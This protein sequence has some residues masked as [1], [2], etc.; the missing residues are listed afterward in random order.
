MTAALF[1]FMTFF[2][3]TSTAGDITITPQY[4]IVVPAE[5]TKNEMHAATVLQ[6]YLK[7]ISGKSLRIVKEN[8]YK[9]EPAI[10]VGNTSAAEALGKIKS[11][12][13]VIASN[14]Q[15]VFIKGG[16][17]KGVVYGVYTLLETYLGCRKYSNG[18]ASV[19]SGKVSL[20]SKLN[21]R[22]E[23]AFIYRETY[24]PSAFDNEFLEWHKL[25]RFEDLWGVWGHSFFKI[26]PPKTYF[27]AHPEYYALV[28][29]KRQATQLC[30]SNDAVFNIA[31][32]Y[33]RKAIADNP[34][35]MY[36]S[37]GAEDG[38]GFCTCDQCSK[39]STE[40]GGPQGPLVRFVNR[41]A[42]K[43]PRQTF[44][45]LAYL[46]TARPPQK[47]KPAANVYIMLSSIDAE[48]QVPL[49][50]ANSFVKNLDGWGAV[51]D[52]LFLWDYTTQFTNYLTPF[53]DYNQQ[54]PNLQF[55]AGKKVKGIFLQGSGNTYGD[56]A[57]L[58]AYLQAKLLWNPAAKNVMNEFIDGYYG[59]SAPAI[60]EYIDALTATVQQSASKLDIYGGPVNVPYLTPASI[61]KYSALLDKAEKAAEKTTLPRI[62]NARLPLE[63]AVLQQSRF[64]GTEQYGYLIP[65]GNG[66]T[67]NP[68]W[69]ARVQ[70]FTAQ[71]KAAG[72]TELSEGGMGPDA[73]QQEWAAIFAHKWVNS[74]AFKA[75]VTLVNAYAPEYPAKR[76]ATLTDGLEGTKDFSV[77]WLYIYGKDLI[78]TID[79][80]QSKPI[81]K[82]QMNFLSDPRHYIFNPAKI[83]VEASVDGVTFKPL[84]TQ[85]PVQPVDENYTAQINTFRF[86]M[87][88]AQARYVRITGVCQAAVP[89]WRG[90]PEGKKPAVCCDEIY[91]Q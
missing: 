15:D 26:V 50:A 45:T 57:E 58:K 22:Q 35:A 53:P 82:V 9:K 37:I 34:D 5:A 75:K 80:G 81:S 3:C 40:D 18:A 43:F 46:Y 7:R 79:L 71:S 84:P 31:V 8:T 76:E 62:S 56:M 27:A 33:F 16:S 19:P 14:T 65:N 17:G 32:D 10:F 38:A 29:G 87:P 85:Q 72:V 11:E 21:D 70:Q 83:T 23:P 55:L 63:Y 51:T 49:S 68:K 86:S 67:A 42:G 89:V 91:V 41:V 52:N 60:K 39:A 30:L 59:K 88:A 6:N 25:H 64:Y 12:G 78:A 90:A 20:P 61:D 66:Y 13:F 2:G 73:Y 44:T 4:V 69:P 36:W 24:Y 54:Q 48:R 74:I 47:T 1:L 28:N 77:N